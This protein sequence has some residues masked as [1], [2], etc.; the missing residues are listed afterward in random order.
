MRIFLWFFWPEDD[1]LGEHGKIHFVFSW[2][3]SFLCW[4]IVVRLLEEAYK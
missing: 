4:L 1:M 2:I 3:R